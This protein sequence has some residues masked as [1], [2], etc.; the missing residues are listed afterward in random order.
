MTKLGSTMPMRST[1]GSAGYDIFSHKKIVLPPKQQI[2][3]EVPFIFE[4]ELDDTLEFRLFVRSSFAI[5]KKVR[6]IHNG[7]KNIEYVT[8]E[9]KKKSSYTITLLNDNDEEICIKEGE[10]FAQFVVCDKNSTLEDMVLGYVP[11][12]ELNKHRILLGEVKESGS[13]GLFEYILGEDIVLGPDEQK[14]F[15]TGLRSLINEGTWTGITSHPDVR[16][17]VMLANQTAVIDR[18]YA[19]TK[20]YGHCFVALVNLVGQELTLPKGTKLMKFWTEKYYVLKN[21]TT[22]DKTRVG[23]IGSTD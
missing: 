23:G 21:E 7:N 9:P 2:S 10:H 1:T 22:S 13:P 4:G 5:N 15:A 6:L 16:E 17:K 20:N 19:F 11:S 14:T 18:D 8:L 3:I 12:E